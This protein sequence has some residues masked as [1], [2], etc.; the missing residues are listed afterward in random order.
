MPN[1]L[2][3]D[4]ASRIFIGKVPENDKEISYEITIKF[5]SGIIKITDRFLFHIYKN[6]VICA[7]EQVSSIKTDV[8]AYRV[9]TIEIGVRIYAFL[10]NGVAGL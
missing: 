5:T 9:S 10:A 7:F 8:Y 2:H 6:I 3:Y 1:W 4:Q